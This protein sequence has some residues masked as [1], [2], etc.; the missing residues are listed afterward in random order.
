M[1]P[2]D[3][4]VSSYVDNL[5]TRVI[6]GRRPAEDAAR[7]Y[8]NRLVAKALT[9][10]AIE[11]SA[12]EVAAACAHEAVKG[13]VM[14]AKALAKAEAEKKI[15][16]QD[17][18]VE[19]KA[20]AAG[21]ARVAVARWVQAAEKAKEASKEASTNQGAEREAAASAAKIAVRQWISK[22]TETTSKEGERK[23][24]NACARVA[25]AR[26]LEKAKQSI[27]AEGQKEQHFPEAVKR[28]ES[29]AFERAV[30]Q[31]DPRQVAAMCA[32]HAV[33]LY[34][35]QAKE[36]IR[37]QGT[38]VSACSAVEQVHST[39]V[40]AA[41]KIAAATQPTIENLEGMILEEEADPAVSPS[42]K[43]PM[44]PSGTAP[45]K[46]R[47][48]PKES[49]VSSPS[50]WDSWTAPPSPE[51]FEADVQ[52]AAKRSK[53]LPVRIQMNPEEERKRDVELLQKR[54]QEN[55][56]R[57]RQTQEDLRSEHN[58]SFLHSLVVSKELPGSNLS[59]PQ[60]PPKPKPA[61][62]RASSRRGYGKPKRNES[63]RSSS[64]RPRKAEK[65]DTLELD[66][67]NT[68]A[69]IEADMPRPDL[70]DPV[71]RAYLAVYKSTV[72]KRGDDFDACTRG[73]GSTCEARG[74]LGMCVMQRGDQRVPPTGTPSPRK[75]QVG[76]SLGFCHGKTRKAWFWPRKGAVPPMETAVLALL[77][78]NP[79]P[80]EVTAKAAA[81][82][83]Q[84]FTTPAVQ[85]MQQVN[86]W[87]QTCTDTRSGC[88]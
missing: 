27:D 14:K 6:T 72:C 69:E 44:K 77:N 9:Q 11:G 78:G 61:K 31:G 35:D 16:T 22:A 64:E 84:Y 88:P 45:K 39:V 43:S 70:D 55:L 51:Q 17:S 12:R 1:A 21:C 41:S 3:A 52:A 67:S 34:L 2:T 26:F 75:T 24:A 10:K 66:A 29:K 57:V 65:D 79:P 7:Q 58:R 71:L 13:Y 28:N 38:E 68:L 19:E 33:K 54:H 63:R 83:R 59:R 18:G 42:G 49:K 60:L 8:V 81:A 85:K 47:P 73:A 62:G 86:S 23:V 80:I 76:C 30:E 32:R 20:L 46:K 48:M 5:L 40:K 15:E 74:C 36:T 4:A 53:H 82:A 56:Q 25:V 87:A 50:A 37:R